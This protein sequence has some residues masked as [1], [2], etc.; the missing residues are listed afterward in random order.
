[1]DKSTHSFDDWFDHLQMQLADRGIP[2]HDR[3][4]VVQDY[5]DGKD[6]HDVLDDIAAEYDV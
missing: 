4:A 1:M 2:F 5:E 3:D 6:M